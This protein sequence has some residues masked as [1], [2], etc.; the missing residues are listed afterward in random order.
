MCR[1]YALYIYRYR[2]AG[3]EVIE[4]LSKFSSCVERASIDE[5]YIDLT[6]EVGK[7]LAGLGTGEVITAS[8]LP[9]TFVE[10]WKPDSDKIKEDG[11]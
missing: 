6:Q 7:R 3:A 11:E 4:V 1:L 8:Q 5:A 9:N 10:G 2:A